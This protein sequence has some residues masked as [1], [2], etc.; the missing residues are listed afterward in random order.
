MKTT[1]KDKLG[2]QKMFM[3]SKFNPSRKE[4][5][6]AGWE[7]SG[8]TATRRSEY[9]LNDQEAVK[10]HR[11]INQSHLRGMPHKASCEKQD[12][13]DCHQDLLSHTKDRGKDMLRK[14]RAWLQ[15]DL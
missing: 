8:I 4:E 6:K 14:P 2:E 11:H 12:K 1:N 13:P 10:S 5:A 15:S 9:S 7:S 3:L